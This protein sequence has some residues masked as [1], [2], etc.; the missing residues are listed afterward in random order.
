MAQSG[1]QRERNV[2]QWCVCLGCVLWLS[3][4]PVWAKSPASAVYEAIQQSVEA[5][6]HARVIP[7]ARA[8]LKRFPHDPQRPQVLFWLAEGLYAVQAYQAAADT[9]RLLMQEAPSFDQAIT[10]RRHLALCYVQM[11]HYN[12][13]L[14]SL[15][16]LLEQF[17]GMAGRERIIGHMAAVYFKQGR[18]DEA[19]PLYEQLLL[20]PEPPVPTSVL[21]LRLG[22]CALYMQQLA[23]AQRHYLTLI[24]NFADSAEAAQ[25]RYQLG[26]IAMLQQQYDVA[27]DDFRRLLQTSWVGTMGVRV[28]YAI[29][30]TFF[31]QGQAEQAVAYLT[32][33]HL[34]AQPLG[35]DSLLAQVHD[36]LQVRAYTDAIDRLTRALAQIEDAAR[37][38]PV[39]WLLARALVESGRTA[40]ALAVLDDFI[41][42]FPASPQVATAQRWRGDLLARSTDVSRALI[43]YQA[44]LSQA[45]DDEQIEQLLLA[46]ADLYQSHHALAEAMVIWRRLLQDYPLSPRHRRVTLQLGAALVQQGAIAEAVTHYRGL[47]AT[48]LP[49]AVRQQTQLQLAWA[50]LKGREY[51]LAR[52]MY[53]KLLDTGP[54]TNTLQQARY[55]LGWILQLQGRYEASNAQWQTLLGLELPP[56]QRGDVSWRLASNLMALERKQEACHRLQDVVTTN[57]TAPYVRLASRQLQ[58]CWLEQHRYREALQQ[59]SAAGSYNPLAVFQVASDAARAE[60]LLKAKRYRQARYVL[61]QI[62]ALPVVTPLTD[63][64]VF[65]IAESYLAEG[66]SRRAM[67]YYRDMILQFARTPLLALASYR[68]GVILLQAGRLQAAIQPLQQAAQST[69]EADIRERSWYDLGKIYVQLEQREAAVAVL[70]RLL[71]EGTMAFATAAEYLNVG[72]MLQQM[73]D[74]KTALQVLQHIAK[75]ASDRR[76]RAEVQFWIAETYQLQGDV[77]TALHAYQQVASQYPNVQKW[78]LTALFRAGEIY[79]Q[80][81]QYAE[82]IKMYQ[83]VAAADPDNPRGRYA[84]QRVRRLKTKTANAAGKEG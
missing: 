77:G 27:R 19:L 47:L 26:T 17:P 42:R 78:A 84:A 53:L 36:L 22:D 7:A 14:Q 28:H 1:A 37:A 41:R 57:T 12:T 83:R 4:L 21:Y 24:R 73:A 74:Y 6:A 23:Q 72:L 40:R 15:S 32:Q 62:V 25:A 63:E 82:A 29:A 33:R 30:W 35:M 34:L 59:A 56:A 65:M 71:Q 70:R 43:A 66:D 3:A 76:I 69:S 58:A 81:Q 64:A 44:A 79:E 52:D 9:Y 2:L 46:M 13:A 54:D 50:Y 31:Y 51:D 60:R 18:F 55:W 5:H 8:F 67:Q 38:Q 48:E 75:Q 39:L 20:I 10:A 45:H 16:G 49:P 80:R 61:Q 68:E 11:R